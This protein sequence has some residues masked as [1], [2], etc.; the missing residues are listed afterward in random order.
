M[1]KYAV[2]KGTER[3]IAR[4][5]GGQRHGHLG[6]ADVVSDWLSVEVKHR[7]TIPAWIKDAMDQAKANAD[8]GKLALVVLHEHG[9]RSDG[10]LVILTLGDFR[11]WFG[12]EP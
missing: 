4:R 5:L 9:A 7:K 12:D 1:S 2:Y 8:P 3:R 10:D 11:D 6:G